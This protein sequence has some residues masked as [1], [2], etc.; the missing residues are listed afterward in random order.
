MYTWRFRRQKQKYMFL[1]TVSTQSSYKE[2]QTF[3]RC[4]T[5]AD[6]AWDVPNISYGDV[7]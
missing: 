3:L 4:E 6:I 2:K 5:Q 7:I 1:V